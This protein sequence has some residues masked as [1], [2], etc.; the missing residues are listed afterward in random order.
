MAYHHIA[1]LKENSRGKIKMDLDLEEVSKG[2]PMRDTWNIFAFI[3]VLHC[4]CFAKR[5][6]QKLSLNV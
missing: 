4:S 2:P 1:W 3:L 5:V 6:T